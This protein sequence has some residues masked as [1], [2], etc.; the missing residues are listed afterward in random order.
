MQ[1]ICRD[2]VIWTHVFSLSPFVAQGLLQK[3]IEDLRLNQ[4]HRRE[5]DPETTG[6]IDEFIQKLALMSIGVSLPFKIVVDDPAGNSHIE[7]PH[8]PS[9]D[10]NMT[11][12]HY[13]RSE[14]QDLECGLQPDMTHDRP[15]ETPRVLP[16]R[17]AG[18]DKFVQE[19]NIAQ[20]EVIQMPTECHACNAP[21]FA[22]MCMTDIPHFKVRGKKIWRE[23]SHF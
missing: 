19:A 20:K 17:N 3:A 23:I 22:C 18:L 8:A 2:S 4:E 10:R 5:I 16:H 21:G 15:S 12:T 1:S 9:A 6:K 14:A 11:T 7:N 13:Y